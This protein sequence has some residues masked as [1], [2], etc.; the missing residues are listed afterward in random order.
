M[1]A[2]GEASKLDGYGVK[3]TQIGHVWPLSLIVAGCWL[4]ASE[5][6][7]EA[8]KAQQWWCAALLPAIIVVCD[9]RS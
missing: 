1:M 3:A 8:K 5:L 7:V 2:A 4:W 9:D 6:V